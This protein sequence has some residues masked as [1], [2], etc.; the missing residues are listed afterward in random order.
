MLQVL[1]FYLGPNYIKKNFKTKKVF[2]RELFKGFY[3][4]KEAIKYYL[5]NT[6]LSEIIH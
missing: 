2:E 4:K 1:S 6:I 3:Y 5:A